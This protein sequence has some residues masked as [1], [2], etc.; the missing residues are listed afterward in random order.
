MSEPELTGY[1][2]QGVEVDLLRACLR[3]DELEV[4]ATPLVLKLLAL[5]C[6]R[7]GE[8]CT[9]AEIFA[10][11]WPRQEVSD[12]ALNKLISRLRELLGPYAPALVTVRKQGLR[13]DAPVQLLTRAPAPVAVSA[14]LEAPAAVTISTPRDR[15]PP[16][17]RP[18]SGYW[19]LLAVPVLVLLVWAWLRPAA[20]T[21]TTSELL[22]FVG[23]ALRE[24]DLNA[25]SAETAT[26]LRSAEQA[27]N[28]GDA[29]QARR[30]LQS[31]ELSD[32]RSAVLPALRVISTAVTRVKPP[33]NCWR[34][35]VPAWAQATAPPHICWSLMHRPSRDLW[36]RNAPRSMRC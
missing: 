33:P 6:G 27:M 8:L 29:A 21:P 34:A 25:A 7:A 1:R 19:L 5:L 22:V 10:C 20:S 9:R 36:N 17:V 16:L 3:I 32:E 14:T 11:V 12:D 4:V 28:R 24:S 23:F 31:A 18:V 2:F 35:R 13:L 30:L 26:V 15:G